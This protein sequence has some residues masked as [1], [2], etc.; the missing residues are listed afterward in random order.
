MEYSGLIIFA[1][2]IFFR[3]SYGSEFIKLTTVEKGKV[4]EFNIKSGKEIIILFLLI[5]LCLLIT[6]IY[7]TLTNNEHIVP[8]LF[9]G[10]FSY[11][12]YKKRTIPRINYLQEIDL[13]SSFI[14]EVK[15]METYKCIAFPFFITFYSMV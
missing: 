2:Y 7:F 13:P 8:I 5:M 12:F 14:K 11:I 3:K 15:K 6:F 1:F 10:L 4:A 9:W